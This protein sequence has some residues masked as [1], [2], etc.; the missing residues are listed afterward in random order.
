VNGLDS[1]LARIPLTGGRHWRNLSWTMNGSD[2]VPEDSEQLYVFTPPRPLSRGDSVVIGWEFE[3]R[4]PN[5]VTRNGG[6]TQEFILPSGVVLTGFSPSFAPVIGFMEQV[7]ETKDNT[8]EPRRYTRDYYRGV[9]RASY[10]ATA[11]FPARVSVTGPEEYALNSVGVC[12][13]DTVRDGWRTQVW[14]TDHPV[15]ILNIVC[16][17]WQVKQGDGTRLFY[18]PAHAYNVEE[19][20]A[21]LDAARRWYSEWF[22]PYPWREL[23]LSEFP[24][25]AGYA[26]GF[27]TN[28]TF[29]ENI[30]FLTRNDAKSNAT[31]LVTAHEAA[32][33]WWGNILTPAS[34]PGGD[35]LS[36]GTSHFATLLLFEKVKGP[37]GRMEFAKGL[38][39]RYGD[40][41]RADDERP[42][43][44]VDG[45]RRYDTT[46]IYDR[47]GWVFWMVYD[48]LGHDRALAGY[49][50]FFRTWSVS[51]DHPALQDFV[52][53][54]RPY[55]ADPAAYDAFVKQWFEDKV[56]PEYRIEGATKVKQG[57]GYEVAVTVTNAGTGVMPVEVAATSGE[58]WQEPDSAD[59]AAPYV[60][61]PEYAD[62]RATVTLGA[63]ETKTVT[64]RCAFE[65]QAV[66]VDPDV[67]VLQLKRKQAT[68]TL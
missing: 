53:A 11:W 41:R 50:D 5:G 67:R 25:L 59:A 42:M 55:A 63:G 34:G 24:G 15:K 27:G 68:A 3:G 32:H 35:F 45:K 60:Q 33:Q 16:G 44:D 58:R 7:G 14:E 37:R 1:T 21:T 47:G 56:V 48:F 10:G 30:G 52:A 46:V 28:I 38:E 49:R 31:F 4:M 29:S 26:Q 2:Y 13:S 19:M 40:N 23:K 36:E 20:S 65:P 6:N 22:L 57:D 39:A 9:T 51:R 61:N 62:A 18:H 43:Y 12:T 66:V 17:R 8:T 64:I 54:M